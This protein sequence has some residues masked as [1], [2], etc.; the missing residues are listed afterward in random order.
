MRSFDPGSQR[1]QTPRDEVVLLPLTETPVSEQTLA[2]IHTR[3][4]GKR[5]VG[6]QEI[7]ERATASGGVSI[8][9]GWEFYAPIA[10][11]QSTIFDL[12]PRAVAFVDEPTRVNQELEAWCDEINDATNRSN[13][14][15]VARPDIVYCT[16]PA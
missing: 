1:S 8:F 9:P 16:P 10:G 14:G 15:S 7:L 6:S 5:V 4:S 2:A 3:L 11:L 13:I 12:L